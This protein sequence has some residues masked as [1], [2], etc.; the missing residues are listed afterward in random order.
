VEGYVNDA[1]DLV[2]QSSVAEHQGIKKRMTEKRRGGW[3]KK[4]TEEESKAKAREGS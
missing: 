4:T 2:S 1:P 3:K